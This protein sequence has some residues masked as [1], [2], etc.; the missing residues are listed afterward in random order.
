MVSYP[1][2]FFHGFCP[3]N[4]NVKSHFRHYIIETVHDIPDYEGGT[5]PETVNRMEDYY[6]YDDRVGEPYYMVYGSFKPD[7]VQCAKLIA[8]FDDLKEAIELAEHLSG[9][10]VSETDVPIYK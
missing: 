2:R 6:V 4:G 7:F 8:T 5:I 1:N 10:V 3:N 9:N